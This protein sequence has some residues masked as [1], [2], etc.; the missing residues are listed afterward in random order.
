MLKFNK[1][2]SVLNLMSLIG[3]VL[4]VVIRIF[5]SRTLSTQGDN[6]ITFGIAVFMIVGLTT[7]FLKRKKK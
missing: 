3:I 1:L 4:L 7:E 6:A 2:I 5:F